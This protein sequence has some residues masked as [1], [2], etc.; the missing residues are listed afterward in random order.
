MRVDR[1]AWRQIPR[2]PQRATSQPLVALGR[3]HA[4]FQ[5]RDTS[6]AA[7]KSNLRREKS[8]FENG[9]IG[10]PEAARRKW[11]PATLGD[12]H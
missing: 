5:T 3:C 8:V 11:P 1:N 9:L 2:A 4:L 7:R 6:C 10:A 12:C